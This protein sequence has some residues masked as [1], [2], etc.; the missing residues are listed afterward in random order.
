MEKAKLMTGTNP[1]TGK[2]NFG[3]FYKGT[4]GADAVMN[5]NEAFGGRWGE[6]WRM[7]ELKMELNSDTMKDAFAFMK[8]LNTY[9]PAGVVANQGGELFG[10]ADN[11]IAINMRCNPAVVNNFNALGLGDRYAVSRL[12]INEAEDMGGMFAGSPVGIAST[13][14]VKD[15][16]WEWLKFTASETFMNYFWENQKYE[17]LPV[18]KAALNIDSIKNDANYT[19]VMNTLPYLWTPR[20]VYRAGQPKTIL[21]TAFEDVML[22]NTDIAATLDAA[23]KEAEDWVAQQ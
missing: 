22:N 9:A 7:N 14:D 12:Y 3:V 16:A 23:Q 2:E 11:N 1:K 8:E 20:Y 4:D 15:A 18:L 21:T 19:A 10:T 13:S 17:G 5:V 6:G